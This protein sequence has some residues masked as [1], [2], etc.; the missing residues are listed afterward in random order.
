MAKL[1]IKVQSFSR[2]P[3]PRFKR[4]GEHSGEAFREDVLLPA[5]KKHG[6]DIVVDLDGTM[7]YGSSF[8]EECF[9]GLIRAGVEPSIAI[10]IANNLKSDED[11][12]LKSEIQEYVQDAVDQRA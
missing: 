4:L 8:L 11:E 3:G 9:G 2:F 7:G 5:I 6:G 10:S 1:L 12:S